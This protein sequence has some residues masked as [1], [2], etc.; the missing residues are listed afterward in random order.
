MGVNLK[1]AL[2]Y[3][4]KRDCEMRLRGRNSLPGCDVYVLGSLKYLGFDCRDGYHILS[5]RGL[6]SCHQLKVHRE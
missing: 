3:A 5:E 2:V 1:V 4:E 6:S